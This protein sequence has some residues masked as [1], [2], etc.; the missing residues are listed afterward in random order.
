MYALGMPKMKKKTKYQSGFTLIE[1][2]VVIAIIA[3]LAALL[4]PALAKAKAKAGQT[5]CLSNM[6]QIGVG[7]MLYTGDNQ[8]VF[9]GSASQGAQHQADDW[10]YWNDGYPV[11]Q[12]MLIQAIG[13]N[14]G[15]TNI[16]LCPLDRRT[17][18]LPPFN[19]SYTM[20]SDVYPDAT[21]ANVNHG[22]TSFGGTLY[23]GPP[24]LK[25][26]QTQIRHPS[27]TLMT[28]EELVSSGEPD[29]GRFELV[30]A[31]GVTPANSLSSRHNNKADIA[32]ADGHVATILPKTVSANPQSFQPDF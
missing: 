18:A 3:I 32:F 1:L 8:D 6:K 14:A 2:L 27:Q 17:G 16:L 4:L 25:F 26:K 12:S 31:D 30:Q 28:A 19:Y 7:T 9:F 20:V 22:I 10:I 13:G 5:A 29:D 15:T 23:G 11:Q 21:G 24:E